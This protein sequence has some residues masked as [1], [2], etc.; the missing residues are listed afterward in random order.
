MNAVE[1]ADDLANLAVQPFEAAEFP[2]QFMAAF[3]KKETQLKRLRKD[4]TN[5]SDVPDRVLLQSNIHL[6]VCPAG[7]T[8][9]TLRLL[10][11]SLQTA[12]AK[13]KFILATDGET[14]EAEELST[15]ESIASE[16]AKLAEHIGLESFAS[17]EGTHLR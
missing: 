7:E 2:F 14:L 1:I 12:K 17:W 11:G 16:F 13:A 6:A 3:D 8:H 9:A 4:D 5:R 10:K 15:G